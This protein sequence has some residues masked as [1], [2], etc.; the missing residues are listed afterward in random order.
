MHCFW[1]LGETLEAMASDSDGE[2]SGSEFF[3]HDRE[4]SST[5]LGSSSGSESDAD[6]QE[7]S[8][9]LL[10]QQLRQRSQAASALTGMKRPITMVTAP[11]AMNV[12]QPPLKG[13][14]PSLLPPPSA[15]MIAR[16]PGVGN[17][18]VGV[19][20]GPMYIGH[21]ISSRDRDPEGPPHICYKCN[22]PIAIYGKLVSCHQK[23]LMFLKHV[24]IVIFSLVV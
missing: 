2:D 4:D 11:A 15:P 23:F 24:F 13:S 21:A 20:P 16:P 7:E 3:G 14:K 12:G 18:P 19:Q 8:G 1:T 22:T 6:T 10:T 5:S 17:A 9:G